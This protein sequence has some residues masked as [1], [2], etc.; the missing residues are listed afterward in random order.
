MDVKQLFEGATGVLLV[1]AL[2][3]LGAVFGLSAAILTRGITG[4]TF[5]QLWGSVL[6]SGIGATATLWVALYSQRLVERRELRRPVNELRSQFDDLH[7]LTYALVDAIE[8][9]GEIDPEE[10]SRYSDKTFSNEYR[11]RRSDIYIALE[12]VE[13]ASEKIQP[14]PT[15]P[16]TLMTKVNQFK[17]RI[18][19]HAFDG[20][21]RAMQAMDEH[22]MTPAKMKEELGEA[23]KQAWHAHSGCAEAINFLSKQI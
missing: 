10:A 1:I 18:G 13:K 15:L 5:P 6:G 23:R 2:L 8:Q 16:P 22:W 21:E 12:R 11:Q 19:G 3:C 9:A 20:H 4:E 17:E 14:G 7:S